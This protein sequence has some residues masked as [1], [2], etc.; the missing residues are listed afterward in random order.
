MDTGEG[1]DDNLAK[2]DSHRIHVSHEK[3]PGWLGYIEDEILP[4]YIGIIQNHCKHP[5]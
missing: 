2:D 3:Y 4:S 1:P 5:Y